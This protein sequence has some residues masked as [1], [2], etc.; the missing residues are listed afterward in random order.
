[1][2]NSTVLPDSGTRTISGILPKA[3]AFYYLVS[4][5]FSAD[6]YTVGPFPDYD[7]C[8]KAMCRHSQE[9][10]RID[11]QENC[12]DAELNKDEQEG[13]IRLVDRFPDHDNHTT[14]TAFSLPSPEHLKIEF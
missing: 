10:C 2:C 13:T 6:G 7:K 9:E 14:W 8:W 1:M 12:Y 11:T 5:S 4:Y 3:T